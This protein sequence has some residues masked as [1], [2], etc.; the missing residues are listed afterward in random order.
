MLTVDHW[1]PI[2][3]SLA[4]AVGSHVNVRLV[5]NNVFDKEPPAFALTGSAANFTA[6][7]GR[8]RSAGASPDA[9]ALS[10]ALC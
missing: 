8:P 10:F 3:S 4:Y 5:V 7:T 6:A 2:N 9:A 1:W